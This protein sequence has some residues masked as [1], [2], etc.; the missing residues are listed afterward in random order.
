MVLGPVVG[1][2]V[3]TAAGFSAAFVVSGVIGVLAL[4]T[5]LRVPRDRFTTA[6]RNGDTRHL[7]QALRR[8]AAGL[9][10]IITDPAIRLVSLVEGMLWMGIGSLQAYLPLYA[11]TVH[12]ST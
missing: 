2:A 3:L 1:G 11:L 9:W 10:E 4:L 8:L 5:M 6:S 7:G 12:I